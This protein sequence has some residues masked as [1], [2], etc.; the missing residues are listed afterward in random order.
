MKKTEYK[1]TTIHYRVFGNGN[2]LVFLHGFLEDSTMWDEFIKPFEANHKIILVDLPCHGQSRFIG[3][4]CSMIFMANAVKQIL[5]IENVNNPKVIGHSMGGYVGLELA[6]LTQINLTLLHSN[7]W[8]DS[9]EKK[10]DR[11]RV[12]DIVKNKKEFFIS[13]AIPNLFYLKN[14]ELCCPIIKNLIISANNIP[15]NEIQ[16]L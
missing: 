14:R 16:N 8:A 7:F 6:K 3:K 11:D 12:V 2:P 1:D 13:E 10:I 5:D 15:E 9:L 4:E